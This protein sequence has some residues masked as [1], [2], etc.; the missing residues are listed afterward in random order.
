MVAQ[1]YCSN[2]HSLPACPGSALRSRDLRQKVN[3]LLDCKLVRHRVPNLSQAKP[4]II[5][6][7][8]G[9]AELKKWWRWNYL[10]DSSVGQT[11]IQVSIILYGSSRRN[12][13]FLG[14]GQEA[15]SLLSSSMQ[16]RRHPDFSF[17]A[18]LRKCATSLA[19]FHLD[20][21]Y[22]PILDGGGKVARGCVRE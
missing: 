18:R 15:A 17:G 11:Y 2:S 14:L 20:R 21:S 5:G 19:N 6:H 9:W 1:L 8:S 16:K 12:Q 4:A 7:F 3:G 22:D 13:F 10:V